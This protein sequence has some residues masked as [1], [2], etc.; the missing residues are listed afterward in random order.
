M[1]ALILF[2]PLSLFAQTTPSTVDY[3]YLKAEDQKYFKNDS[4]E[5]NNQLE[6]IDLN[7]KEINKLHAEVASLK[8]QLASLMSEIEKLKKKQ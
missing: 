6:R 5:G 4:R 1:Y 8:S 2:I 3:G 7:V